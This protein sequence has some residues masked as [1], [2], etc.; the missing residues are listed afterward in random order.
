MKKAL[1]KE[2]E[3]KQ[4]LNAQSK[5][6]Q[7][8]QQ[9][10]LSQDRAAAIIQKCKCSSTTCV[11]NMLERMC[12]KLSLYL[13]IDYRGYT[14]RKKRWAPDMERRI[15]EVLN[16]AKTPDEGVQY[17]KKQGLEDN[18]VA[19]IMQ[20]LYPNYSCNLLSARFGQGG[21]TSHRIPLSSHEQQL[22]LI[23]F[24]QNV[25][26]FVPFKSQNLSC[27]QN[28]ANVINRFTCKTKM[29]TRIC[30]AIR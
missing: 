6:Q 5:N 17:L 27:F 20:R 2:K 19:L 29:F 12:T 8:Q 4:V 7:Q 25:S 10:H 22:E 21:T 26:V 23:G 15:E 3:H 11:I 14:M 1:A 13:K 16:I 24:S 28:H 9:Q 30:G 18:D